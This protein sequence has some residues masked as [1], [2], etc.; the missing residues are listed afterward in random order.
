MQKLFVSF[1]GVSRIPLT[2]I[3]Y[4]AEPLSYQRVGSLVYISNKYWRGVYDTKSNTVRE[5]GLTPPAIPSLVYSA[6][7]SLVPGIYSVCLTTEASDGRLSGNSEIAVIELTITGGITISNFVT[8]MVVWITDPSGSTFYFAGRSASIQA[9]PGVTELPSLWASPPFNFS[10]I[11]LHGGRMW[12]ANEGLLYYSFPFGYEWFNL[13]SDVFVFTEDIWMLAPTSYGLFVGFEDE[14]IFLV[15]TDPK[16]MKPTRVGD[17]VIKGSLVYGDRMGDLG[18]N[19]PVWLT[20]SGF[21]A[22]QRPTFGTFE[23][24]R[25]TPLSQN[26]VKFDVGSRAASLFRLV[27]GEPQIIS[28]FPSRSKVAFGDSVTAEVIRMG[29]VFVNEFEKVQDDFVGLS[30]VVTAEIT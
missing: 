16:K 12:G 3:P 27:E 6:V 10:V 24:G 5:C 2:D 28:A 17:G 20:K 25:V 22:A 9:L 14:V 13:Y 7:G 15:G 21:V 1:D 11:A 18:D 26:K 4:P 8:G 19:V 29:R 30:E 23:E